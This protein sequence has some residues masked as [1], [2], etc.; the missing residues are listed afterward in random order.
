MTIRV[1]QTIQVPQ[2]VINTLNEVVQYYI[3]S[4][5]DDFHEKRM[6]SLA[7]STHIYHKLKLLQ[8][9]LDE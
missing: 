8:D 5:Y 7:T 1:S 4:E 3:P 2:V 9:Y 6:E